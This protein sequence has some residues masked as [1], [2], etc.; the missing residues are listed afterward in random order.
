[1]KW[2]CNHNWVKIKETRAEP[3]PYFTAERCSEH[4][5]ERLTSGVTTILWECS[6]CHKIRKEEMLGEAR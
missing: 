2:F 3:R 1:M 4:L 6:K 5:Y